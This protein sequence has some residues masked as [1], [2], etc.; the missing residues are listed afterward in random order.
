MLRGNSEGDIKAELAPEWNELTE[1]VIGAAI[2]VHCELGPGLPESIYEKALCAEFRR[3]GIPFECQVVVPVRYK[4][5]S[6]G[7]FRLDL[8][9]AKKLIVELKSVDALL[10]IHKA[11]AITCLKVLHLPLALLI[12]FNVRLLID[13]VK[14][15][16]ISENE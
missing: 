10:P 16:I 4:G 5:E 14:R 8:L 7:A 9:V 1:G 13:G 15:V 12:N 3:R 6:V 2:E 11:Q